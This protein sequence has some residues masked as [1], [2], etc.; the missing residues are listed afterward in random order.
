[1]PCPR[2]IFNPQ[3]HVRLEVYW[4]GAPHF[5]R[6]WLYC[7]DG[8]QCP[9]MISALVWVFPCQRKEEI[10]LWSDGGNL[11]GRTV[12]RA[13]VR[14]SGNIVIQTGDNSDVTVLTRGQGMANEGGRDQDPS[15]PSFSHQRQPPYAR[16]ASSQDSRTHQVLLD[17]CVSK[18]LDMGISDKESSPI[19][20][21]LINNG[22]PKNVV[23]CNNTAPVVFG[24]NNTI[25]GA[26]QGANF[27]TPIQ[28]GSPLAG[29]R[30]GQHHKGETHQPGASA[31][32]QGQHSSQRQPEHDAHQNDTTSAEIASFRR[33]RRLVKR[34]PPH[35]AARQIEREIQP[36]DGLDFPPI[37]DDETS[38]SEESDDTSG[39]ASDED[40]RETTDVNAGRNTQQSM[41]RPTS[42]I[43]DDTSGE[44]PDED[45]RETT[46]GDSGRYTQQGASRPTFDDVDG[47]LNTEEENQARDGEF[48]RGCPAEGSGKEG[49]S[50]GEDD[51]PTTPPK[52]LLYVDLPEEKSPPE[53]PTAEKQRWSNSQNPTGGS[54]N[55]TNLGEG[56][57]KSMD[58]VRVQSGDN[59]QDND[60]S[61]QAVGELQ[62]IER[63]DD[64][65]EG[66]TAR[67]LVDLYPERPQ[68]ST[69]HTIL[70]LSIP[71]LEQ[72]WLPQ[73]VAPQWQNA[74]QD[75]SSDEDLTS[76]HNFNQNER[77][78]IRDRKEEPA[79]TSNRQ[80]L[81][82]LPFTSGDGGP[83]LDTTEADDTSNVET[84][85]KVP[86][87][88][89][90]PDEGAEEASADVDQQNAQHVST[91]T[92]GNQ[93][94]YDKERGLNI[95]TLDHIKQMT[96][97]FSEAK[98]IA[99][100]A[101]GPVYKSVFPYDGPLKGREVVV[102]VNRSADQGQREFMQEL[103]M[104]R[105]R[106]P[107]LQPLFGICEDERCLSLVSPYMAN[108]DLKSWI[109]DMREPTDWKTRAVIGL[110]VISAIRYYHK[111]AEGPNKKF[112]CDV[113]S[114]NV[115]LDAQNRARLGD[116]G[117]MREVSKDKTHLTRT[118]QNT[119]A[120][121]VGMKG[122]NEE[123]GFGKD[124]E[125]MYMV[126]TDPNICALRP[127]NVRLL[128]NGE[129]TTKN[130]K[131]AVKEL[132]EE[133]KKVPE[134][135]QKCLLYYHSGHGEKSIRNRDGWLLCEDQNMSALQMRK[136]FEGICPT[137][138]LSILDVCFASAV[139]LYM[140]KDGERPVAANTVQS[141]V[142][143]FQWV[144]GLL[145]G[146]LPAW[147]TGFL[148]AWVA[149]GQE[150]GE[151]EQEG[152]VEDLTEET[153]R[154]S[155]ALNSFV[156]RGSLLWASSR[157][158]EQSRVKASSTAEDEISVFTKYIL[159]GLR[160]GNK[161][162]KDNS[163][164]MGG[165]HID[166]IQDFVFVQVK[167]EVGDQQTPSISGQREMWSTFWIAYPPKD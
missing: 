74:N 88:S 23:I 98:R 112:H 121:V 82:V 146:F 24:S 101:F 33:T 75:E 96:G 132:G 79:V 141:P 138:S 155:E 154:G 28:T 60:A 111:K 69:M 126:L 7:E 86:V 70:D 44:A 85:P 100:G 156:P 35:L 59:M 130:I 97:D 6:E 12:Y 83:Q 140:C 32:R 87:D 157:R 18:L 67:P 131:K 34:L 90:N 52:T 81:E 142:T 36:S 38:S 144:T 65:G 58:S 115:F 50:Q 19:V 31:A 54:S 17:E 27:N 64:D 139:Q 102:K 3:R 29:P 108:K 127:E 116:P 20:E 122:R 21:E 137:T 41:S 11:E 163:K 120:V 153:E 4:A 148:P 99:H 92:G 57:P 62:R 135:Q 40:E 84:E 22:Y 158:F 42:E 73:P 106:H 128:T 124:A 77:D 91:G 26:G 110:D 150:Q 47:R 25:G 2:S 13:D 39:E 76:D 63:S 46:D 136:L 89:T 55:T 10:Q 14:G 129:G 93:P 51:G 66:V 49:V 151:E 61:N 160:G 125:E 133:M 119:F 53:S 152:T 37:S 30:F 68:P 113:K 118:G 15:S 149:P 105:C 94:V 147:L 165:M 78:G 9:L 143:Y 109:Q 162:L 104:A 134:S 48:R 5:G 43:S 103:K 167:K 95:F 80:P 45:K 71:S 1:M 164:A 72:Q 114:A 145:L 16:S 117:L 8:C 159:A 166:F 107:H 56:S 123:Q 161:S